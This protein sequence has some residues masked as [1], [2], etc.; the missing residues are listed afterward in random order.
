MAS[1][2]HVIDMGPGAGEMGGRVI[3]AGS[4]KQLLDAPKNP[5]SAE[6]Q[7]LTGRYLRGELSVS[8]RVDRRKVNPKRVIK[9]TG[10][11]ANNLK[12]ST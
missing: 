11:R 9:F 1:A 7:T 8:R 4:Y 12:T 6:P 5:K 2:D 3:F 10:A